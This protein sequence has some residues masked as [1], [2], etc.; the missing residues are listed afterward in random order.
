VLCSRSVPAV[1]TINDIAGLV[2]GA[3]EGAGLGNA[4]LSHINACDG[5]YHM[6]R[7]FSDADVSHVEGSLRVLG[8]VPAAELRFHPNTPKS[9]TSRRQSTGSVDPIRDMEI[10]HKELRQKDL[11]VRCALRYSVL[12]CASNRLIQCGGVRSQRLETLL[13]AAGKRIRSKD[14]KAAKEEIVCAC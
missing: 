1:L 5:I 10:I 14:A 7:A 8:V 4:F 11:A 3:S 2:K 12:C 9:Y 13:T 6:V